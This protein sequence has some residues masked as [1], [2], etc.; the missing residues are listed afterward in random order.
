[1]EEIQETIAQIGSAESTDIETGK[2]LLF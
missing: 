1:L 2:D